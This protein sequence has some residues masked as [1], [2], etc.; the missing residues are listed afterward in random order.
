MIRRSLFAGPKP[1]HRSTYFNLVIS[2]FVRAQTPP[3]PTSLPTRQV[4]KELCVCELIMNVTIL[5]HLTSRSLLNDYASRSEKDNDK[6]G[7][8]GDDCRVQEVR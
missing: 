6:G 4:T 1:I 2:S 3:L 5:G 8:R 7:T